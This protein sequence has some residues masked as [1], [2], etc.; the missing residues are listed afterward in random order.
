VTTDLQREGTASCRLRV[1]DGYWQSRGQP[2]RFPPIAT[3]GLYLEVVLT[4]AHCLEVFVDGPLGRAWSLEMAPLR[5][6][7]PALAVTWDA[8]GVV[9]YLDEVPV[10]ELLV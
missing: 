2:C 8:A 7:P 6:Q 5:H 1:P 3:D 9:L 10:P 4:E